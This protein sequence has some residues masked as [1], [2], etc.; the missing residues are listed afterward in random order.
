M[1]MYSQ[2]L[3]VCR[4]DNTCVKCERTFEKWS[5]Y[6]THVTTVNC[7]VAKQPQPVSAKRNLLGVKQPLSDERKAEVVAKW[8]AKQKQGAI[9]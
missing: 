8:E 9:I 1:T 5:D 3:E 4:I 6:H 2:M 7:L